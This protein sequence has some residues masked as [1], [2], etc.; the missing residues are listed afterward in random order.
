MSNHD[1]TEVPGGVL[2]PADPA[3]LG[4]FPDDEY[5]RRLQ[6]VRRA[7][8]ERDLDALVV[9]SPENI[10]YLTGLS[11][12]GYFTFTMLVVTPVGEPMLLTRA[13]E[14][15]TIARQTPNLVHV[16]YGDGDQAGE[17]AVNALEHLETGATRIG[18]DASS[19][20]FP[21]AVYEEMTSSLTSVEW[22]DT[23]RSSSTDPSFRAGLVDEI[24]LIKSPSEVEHIR[25]AAAITDRSLRAGLSVA[26]VGVNERE[27]AARVYQEMVLGGGEYPGFAPLVRSTDRLFFEHETWADRV[28]RPGDGVLMEMSGCRFRYHAPATRMAYIAS[29]PE[30]SERIRQIALDALD[31][32][33]SAL[34]PGV[35]TGDVYG[36]WQA[37]VDDGL[38]PGRLRRHHCGYTVGIGFPPSWVGSSTVLGIRPEGLVPIE[39]GMVFHLLS[40]ISDEM[41][42]S[43]F[44]S[45]TVHVGEEDTE[46]LTSIRRPL[47]VD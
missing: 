2:R 32:V 38:G 1:I 37:V 3:G 39:A 40:W 42:A 35:L 30:G 8:Q 15:P 29:A 19:M 7:M 47:V 26:G 28:F 21:P 43:Y 31:E 16:G 20:F 41:V 34:R 11:H 25:V 46:V 36:S 6:R 23:S 22:H 45:D 10:Y 27:V 44:V 17:A 4:A 9:T 18:V 14:A 13:M 5:Q 24:R 33:R 12:Q